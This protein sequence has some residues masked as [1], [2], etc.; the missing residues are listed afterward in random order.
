MTS[1]GTAGL[2]QAQGQVQSS[3]L[4]EAAAERHRDLGALLETHTLMGGVDEHGH[5][6]LGVAQHVAHGAAE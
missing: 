1:L 6:A 3:L 4:V 2:G 5:V